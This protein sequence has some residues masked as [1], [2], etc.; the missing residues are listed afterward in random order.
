MHYHQDRFRT[1]NHILPAIPSHGNTT[2][3]Q[4][5]GHRTKF[6]R[7]VFTRHGKQLT[8]SRYARRHRLMSNNVSLTSS[9]STKKNFFNEGRKAQSTRRRNNKWGRWWDTQ[10]KKKKS[11]A[12]I[13][14][15]TVDVVVKGIS[16]FRQRTWGRRQ[17]ISSRSTKNDDTM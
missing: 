3:F 17:S 9:C 7:N 6:E 15:T 12:A 10:R 16:R 13:H 1:N 2:R 4:F 14:I 8:S 11:Y 5:T